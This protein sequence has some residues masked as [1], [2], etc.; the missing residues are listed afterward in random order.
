MR[1][2]FSSTRGA[3][4]ILPLLPY[5]RALRARGHEVLVAGPVDLAATLGPTGFAHAV[6]DHPGDAGLGP[7]WAA[8]RATPEDQ[9][10]TF[11]VR[12]IFAGL[13]AATALPRLRETMRAWQPQ[14]VVRDSVEFAAAVAADAAGLPH[15]RVAVYSG[16]AAASIFAAA[17]GPVDTLRASA[18][19]PAD[20]GASLGAEPVFTSFPPSLDGL[21][22]AARR[23]GPFHVREVV[24]GQPPATTG[25]VWAP[26]GD[27]RPLVY[28]T[29]GTMASGVAEARAVYRVALDAL[30]DLPV[31]GLLTT[32]QGMAPDALGPIPSN[33]HVEA[34]VPQVEALARAAAVV[35]HG[36]SGT[37]IGALAA[38]LPLVVVPLF[39]DQPYNARRV[40][41]LGVGVHLPSPT[42]EALR[43]AVRRALDDP[44]LR[45]GAARVAAEIAALPTIDDAADRLIGMAR[46]T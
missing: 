26:P 44:E 27:P 31:R 2:L 11:I 17:V 45:R 19:L 10:D 34:W 38:G 25:P 36:G 4:H 5:A 37:I 24:E 8:L 6:F 42:A 39:A 46:T 1:I 33:V 32:G 40:A 41:A 3:G 18:G 15:A 35:C 28:V 7:L 23:P 29:F 30:A 43:A 9:R 13:N 21:D 16:A 12:E 22:D 14:L 20:A